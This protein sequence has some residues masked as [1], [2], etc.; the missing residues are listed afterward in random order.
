MYEG[1]YYHALNRT[2]VA[3][4]GQ[5]IR[6]AREILAETRADVRDYPQ[7]NCRADCSVTSGGHLASC[8]FLKR[9]GRPRSV[10]NATTSVTEAPPGRG[11]QRPLRRPV[12]HPAS[13]PAGAQAASASKQPPA[14]AP[15]QKGKKR[16][17]KRPRRS[18]LPRR[19]Q[20]HAE[21]RPPGGDPAKRRP[22]PAA[23]QPPDRVGLG[24]PSF[25]AWKRDRRAGPGAEVT[26]SGQLGHRIVEDQGPVVLFPRPVGLPGILRRF[27]RKEGPRDGA[28]RGQ[29]LGRL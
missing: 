6:A 24:Q 23:A 11:E 9:R 25:Q 10:V 27:R 28:R 29:P 3:H 5:M 1:G 4:R 13:K 21:A 14:K 20:R 22:A 17:G 15:A 7:P 26:P 18:T 19:W 16:K 2:V 12:G 8:D